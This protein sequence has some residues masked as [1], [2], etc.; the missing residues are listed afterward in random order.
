MT[1]AAVVAIPA[2]T[3]I[4]HYRPLP[5]DCESPVVEHIGG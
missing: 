2:Q 4:D 3:M 5:T 1:A